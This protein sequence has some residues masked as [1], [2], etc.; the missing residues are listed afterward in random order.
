VDG[1]FTSLHPAVTVSSPQENMDSMNSYLPINIL[2]SME[3]ISEIT[4]QIFKK[5]A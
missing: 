2:C 3:Q 1:K 4:I 5:E